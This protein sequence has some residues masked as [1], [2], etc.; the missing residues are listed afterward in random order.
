MRRAIGLAF[1]LLLSNAALGEEDGKAASATTRTDFSRAWPPG[2]A[3]A[4]AGLEHSCLENDLGRLKFD[5]RVV[6]RQDINGDG[7]PDFFF[8]YCQFA[9]ER[10]FGRFATNGWACP[11]TTLVL[12]QPSG[13]Y[14]QQEAP[15]V[16][17]IIPSKKKGGS[18][19]LI[20]KKRNYYELC[21]F[22]NY[23]CEY[24]MRYEPA[25]GEFVETC[26]RACQIRAQDWEVTR[27]T[28]RI[29]AA[30]ANA[31][32]SSSAAD[33]YDNCPFRYPPGPLSGAHSEPQSA[34][35]VLVELW[36]KAERACR[37]GGTKPS[38]TQK[39]CAERDEYASRLD[40]ADWCYGQRGDEWSEMIW[41][42][43]TAFSLHPGARTP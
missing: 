27:R 5:P 33:F 42:A 43:C 15:A 29:R 22:N 21:D 35:D 3:E 34:T 37:S 2:A 24:E 14:R 12:S 13:G 6:T 7:R 9:C 41:H 18:S 28:K 17:N 8:Q 30:L 39:A 38:R 11:T 23:P 16:F 20:V 36:H 26:D 40:A 25:V 32:R 10:G 31:C 4:L 1:T 19:R